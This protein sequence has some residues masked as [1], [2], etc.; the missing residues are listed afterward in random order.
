VYEHLQPAT[1]ADTLGKEPFFA[2]F[3]SDSSSVGLSDRSHDVP[4]V[5]GEIGV[6]GLD[7]EP[8]LFGQNDAAAI[9]V[10]HGGDHVA[11]VEYRPDGAAPFVS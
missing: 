5:S 11:K 7:V 9:G 6:V 8:P 4:K 2:W 10:S 3:S 1:W